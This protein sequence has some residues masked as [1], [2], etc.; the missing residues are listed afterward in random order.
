MSTGQRSQDYTRFV[1]SVRGV[2]PAWSEA[3]DVEALLRL[4]K[5]E[6]REAAE[7]LFA[8]LEEDDW[9][10]PPALAEAKIR[11]GV[12][13]MKARLP[14]ANGRMR[15]VIARALVEL[16]AMPRADETVAAVLRSGDLDGG[17]AALSAAE[18]MR[19]PEI[20]DALAWTSLHHPEADVRV[21]A[22]AMLFFMAMLTPDPLSWDYRPL[23]LELGED[24]ETK[25]RAAFE[26]ICHIVGMPPE[27]ADRG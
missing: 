1:E 8:K 16:G 10:V 20:R 9:R 18:G 2:G 4:E 22:G 24:D 21:N 17:L 25:R 15:V 12:M 27:L 14:K 26:E 13:P 5:E 11:G 23:Y 19:S 6:R 3:V 7:L